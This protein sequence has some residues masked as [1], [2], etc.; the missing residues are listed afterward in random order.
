MGAIRRHLAS[1]QNIIYFNHALLV[2]VCDIELVHN[3]LQLT[4]WKKNENIQVVL[5]KIQEFP[6]TS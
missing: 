6:L 5:S 1:I 4:D 3:D 2:E